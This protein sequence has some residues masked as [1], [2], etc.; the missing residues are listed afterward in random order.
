ME[1]ESKAK[2]LGCCQNSQLGLFASE[3]MLGRVGVHGVHGAHG[4]H[5]QSSSVRM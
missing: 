2:V 3:E 5:F 1:F 4:S